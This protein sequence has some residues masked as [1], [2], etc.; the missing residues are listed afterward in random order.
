MLLAETTED[1]LDRRES[2]AASLRQAGYEVLPGS[3]LPRDSEAFYVNALRA[4]LSRVRV[5]AQ[6]LGPYE[7]RKPTGGKT[8]FVALQASEAIQARELPIEIFQWRA[9][10]VELDRV[11]SPPTASFS[12]S[13]RAGGGLEEFKRQILKAL[14]SADAGPWTAA[15]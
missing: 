13:I 5:F 4:D 2:V 6:L 7:G 12:E 1:L 3:D 15:G 9:P 11:T 14:R 10:E 8:S